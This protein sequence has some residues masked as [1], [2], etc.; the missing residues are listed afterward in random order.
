MKTILPF[1]LCLL[2]SAALHGE[3]RRWSNADGTSSFDGEYL[4][5]DDK[6][7]T[8]RRTDGQ[9]FTLARE[10]LHPSDRAW[11]A[12]LGDDGEPETGANPNA[13]FDQLC[14]GDSR[15]AVE[16]KLKN[17]KMVEMGVGETFLGRFGLNGTF[18]TRSKIGGLHC[19]LY[20]DWN[21]DGRL[22][23]ITLQTEPLGESDYGGLLKS[24]W[25]EL[26]DLLMHIHGRPLQAT[27]YPKSSNLENDMFLG[28]HLWRIQSGGSVLLGT[29]MVAGK[30][31]VV[32]R[33]TTDRIDP[34]RVP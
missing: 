16:E 7:V 32:V 2:G 3:T 34:V 8:V 27:G 10:K 15:Q 12:S 11:L 22:K 9:T 13:I 33:F 30:Y 5:H 1:F 14:F 29:S 28:S 25:S 26:A 24:N 17:S 20:F 6:V 4:S 18:R 31:L 23:E 19:E 21:E